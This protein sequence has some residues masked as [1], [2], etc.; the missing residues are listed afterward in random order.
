M[1]VKV[2]SFLRAEDLNGATSKSPVEA[3][4]VGAKFI[5]AKDLGFKSDEGRFELQVRIDGETFDWL[6]N[7]TSLRAIVKTYGDESDEWS[8]KTI[9]MYSVEQNVGGEI[10]Q[11]IYATV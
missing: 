7:K 4:I 1:K 5:E 11:V 10:K 2:D 9:K 3:E 6:A 8:D